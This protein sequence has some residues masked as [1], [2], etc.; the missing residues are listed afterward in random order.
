MSTVR[1]TPELLL[2]A[3]RQGIFPMADEHGEIGWYEP[4]R[5]AI[6]P[7][8]ERFHVP[9]RLARTVRSG[10]FTVT[11]DTAFEQVITACAEPA[12]GRESTW[13]SPEIIRAYSELHRLG[14][15]HSVECWRDGQL[16]GGLY[17]VAVGGLFAGESMFH[18][19][20][21]A[22]KVALVHLVE[23]LRRGGFVLLDSQ[24]IVGPHLLQFGT[25]EIS[26]AEYHRLLRAALQVRAVW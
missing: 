6:I 7:L 9:R 16:A 11:Y 17:G 12:P 25:I 13:I 21:D 10:F 2:A 1:L 20:R 19:V 18:R 5:R 22:S 4:I 8:D 3:Y 23:R 15:A 26:R 24:F 14:Y